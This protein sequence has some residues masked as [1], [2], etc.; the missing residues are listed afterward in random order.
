[1]RSKRLLA[2]LKRGFF[3]TKA[4]VDGD[5]C[6]YRVG[7]T[8]NDQPVGIALARMDVLIDRIL[9][10]CGAEESTIYLTSTDKSNYRFQIY[11]DYKANRKAPKPIW[12][13]ELRAH[14]ISD[15][16]AEVVFGMEADDAMA[17]NQ[18]ETSVICTI[19]KDLDQVPGKHYDFVKDVQY[20]VGEE[21]ALRFFYFQLL[22]GDTTD[23]IP[24]CKGIGPKKA[25]AALAGCETVEEYEEVCLNLYKQAYGKRGYDYLIKF[26]QCLKIKRKEDE[27]L[28]LPVQREELEPEENEVN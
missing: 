11:P 15:W 22:T 26:G 14:L 16:N 2:S 6:T 3:V 17:I 8:T 25:E 27:P 19:D 23:N 18:T 7:F 28:W 10:G 5:I 13:E 9:V 20:E 1:M 12:Y 4:L 24:G 21:T